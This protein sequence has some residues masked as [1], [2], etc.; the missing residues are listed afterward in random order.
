MCRSLI[1]VVLELRHDHNATEQSLVE[2]VTSIC[3]DLGLQSHNVCHGL[4][5]LNM[6]N[7]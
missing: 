6:V 2:Q 3:V 4:V 5:S 1:E 7:E